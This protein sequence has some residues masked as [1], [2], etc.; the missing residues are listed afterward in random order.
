MASIPKIVL[1][2]VTLP[3]SAIVCKIGMNYGDHLAIQE[4]LLGDS[5]L[6]MDRN[7]DL[8][9][10]DPKDPTKGVTDT[11]EVVTKQE[12]SMASMRKY[13]EAF[14]TCCVKEWNVEEPITLENIRALTQK[15]GEFLLAACKELEKKTISKEDKKK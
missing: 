6:S 15:D 1:Q 2:E 8:D 3:D 12:F 9:K 4:A 10:L 5:K 13:D 14:L 11:K 7:I